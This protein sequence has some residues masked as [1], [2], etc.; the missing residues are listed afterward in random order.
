MPTELRYAV[1]SDKSF[2]HCAHQ[3]G[4][5]NPEGATTKARRVQVLVCRVCQSLVLLSKGST[6]NSCMRCNQVNDLLSLVAELRDEVE[7]LSVSD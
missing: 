7:I 3:K 1:Q 5:G 2:F 6:D 4:C